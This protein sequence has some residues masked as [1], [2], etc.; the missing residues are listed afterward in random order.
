[1]LYGVR[2]VKV[3]AYREVGCDP[4][5]WTPLLPI[6]TDFDLAGPPFLLIFLLKLSPFPSSFLYPFTFSTAG[7]P[8]PL[9]LP[10]SPL[11]PSPQPH[12]ILILLLIFILILSY[13]TPIPLTSSHLISILSS[14]VLILSTTSSNLISSY[15]YPT[16]SPHSYNL[17]TIY[18]G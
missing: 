13:P 11:L 16:L 17:N 12:P 3:I 10:S 1:M 14:P 8:L 6:K 18:H 5:S 2:R 9:P 15:P 7:P 4:L